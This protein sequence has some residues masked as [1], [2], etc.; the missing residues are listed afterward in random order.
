MSDR[1]DQQVTR[2][3][4]LGGIVTALAAG[5]AGC[6][7]I[8]GGATAT[9]SPQTAAT[10]N[11]TAGN[12]PA[13]NAT[14]TNA[15]T[16]GPQSPYTQVYRETIGS[17]V[18]VSVTT[19]DGKGVQGSGFVYRDSYIVTN[20][21]VVNDAMDVQVRFSR[22]EWRAGTVVGIDPS[23]D[24]AVIRIRNPPQYANALPLVENEP[25]IGTKVAAIGSPYSLEGSISSGIV[26]A[27]NRSIPAPNGYTI[28]DAI[29][30]DAP[31]NPGNSGGPLLN[32]D[33]EVVGVISSG[34]GENLAFAVS[35]ALMKRVIPALIKT[36]EYHHA[37][38]GIHPRTVTPSIAER[39][40]LDR[41]HGVLVS[42]VVPDGPSA[43]RLRRGDIIVAIDGRRIG[44]VEQLSSYLALE[45]SPGDTVRITVLR[46]GERRTVTVTLGTRPERPGIRR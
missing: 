25:P 37:Y 2:R 1:R 36:G 12:T 33:G 17:V 15:T 3:R 18:L 31:V 6:S 28:P 8:F 41:P 35:A 44:T 4:Y 46:N 24:L 26:S 42:R 45:A 13:G 27:V 23:S 9:D 34:G 14:A 32:L 20:A 43:D 40:G 22:G 39:A 38:L 11:A 16:A 21:H 7:S 29:Q 19:T 5:F 30:T 10:G